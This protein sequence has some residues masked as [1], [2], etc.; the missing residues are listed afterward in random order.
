MYTPSHLAIVGTL[1]PSVDISV[2][3]FLGVSW[4]ILF[5]Y[6]ILGIA[7]MVYSQT[8]LVR[9]QRLLSRQAKTIRK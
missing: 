5:P 1:V 7:L 9:G 2:H 8:R 6:T 3:T 4:D